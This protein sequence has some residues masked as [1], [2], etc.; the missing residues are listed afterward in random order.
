MASALLVGPVLVA[1]NHGDAII[2]GELTAARVLKMALT[3]VVPYAVSTFSSVQA[4]LAYQRDEQTS[5][6]AASHASR[7]G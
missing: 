5:S 7:A 4:A 1:I 6:R 3:L 2:N